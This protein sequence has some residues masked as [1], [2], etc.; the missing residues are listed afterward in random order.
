MHYTV[1]YGAGY[2][3]YI[4]KC[5]HLY[6]PG[7]QVSFQ[8]FFKYFCC[9]EMFHHTNNRTSYMQKN[10]PSGYDRLYCSLWNADLK[11]DVQNAVGF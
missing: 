11:K 1:K 5:L 7:F 4:F 3:G 6:S 8:S 9:Q 2:K 10:E